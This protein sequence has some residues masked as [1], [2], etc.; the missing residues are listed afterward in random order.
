M[1]PTNMRFTR[2]LASRL[3]LRFPE[4]LAGDAVASSEARLSIE[5][6][7]RSCNHLVVTWRLSALR[8]HYRSASAAVTQM[9]AAIGWPQRNSGRSGEGRVEVDSCSVTAAQ[10]L[11]VVYGATNAFPAWLSAR[12]VPAGTGQSDA[13]TLV[14]AALAPHRKCLNGAQ[15]AKSRQKK[16]YECGRTAGLTLTL[17]LETRTRGMGLR[18]LCLRRTPWWPKRKNGNLRWVRSDGKTQVANEYMQVE[19]GQQNSHHVQFISTQH[20]EPLKTAP[21]KEVA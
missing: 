18:T 7:F 12:W 2:N 6:P 17:A 8:V 3:S 11:S 14:E 15:R 1:S 5:S 13:P 21:S 16:E 19:P 4:T 9:E 10:W 20:A